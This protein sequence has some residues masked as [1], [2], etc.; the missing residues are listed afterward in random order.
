M[1]ITYE[2]L[3]S[4]NASQLMINY[5]KSLE[6]QEWDLLELVDRCIEDREGYYVY[7]LFKFADKSNF[8]TIVE[9]FIVAGY[10]LYYAFEYCKDLPFLKE[11]M[12]KCEVG[13]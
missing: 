11:V 4:N 13:V 5:F 7:F 6:K 10:D 12:E 2:L 3:E 8:E 9:K 1:L